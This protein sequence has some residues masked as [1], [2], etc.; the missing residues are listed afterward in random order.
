MFTKGKQYTMF[1]IGSM[2]PV[3]G[4]YEFTVKE[5]QSDGRAV[6]V[7]KGKRKRFL[8]NP[9]ALDKTAMIIE[10]WDVTPKMESEVGHSFVINGRINFSNTTWEEVENLIARNLHSGFDPDNI[11]IRNN[12]SEERYKRN[13]A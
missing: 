1:S 4:R 13:A 9:T 6:I 12:G 7:E 10:G 5:I 3:C 8:I 11:A 2:L